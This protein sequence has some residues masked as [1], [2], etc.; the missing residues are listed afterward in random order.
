MVDIF[1]SLTD[2]DVEKLS[3]YSLTEDELSHVL[4]LFELI[5]DEN[6]TKALELIDAIFSGKKLVADEEKKE[7]SETLKYRKISESYT[8]K[9]LGD[10]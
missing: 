1:E 5:S 7:T 3:T 4:S 8:R 10:I 9:L 2:E 6:K